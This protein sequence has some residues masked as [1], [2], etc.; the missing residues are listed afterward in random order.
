VALKFA[1]TPAL[2][3][4]EREKLRPAL[5]HEAQTLAQVAPD[6]E[7][8]LY[9]RLS[10]F[11][12][13]RGTTGDPSSVAVSLRRVETAIP[14]RGTSCPRPWRIR[15]AYAKAS[16]RQANSGYLRLNP[17]IEKSRENP[18][19][20]RQGLRLPHHGEQE[21]GGW[22]RGTTGETPVPLWGQTVPA[23]LR[24]GG[25]GAAEKS[26]Q[27]KASRAKSSQKKILWV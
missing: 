25:R 13:W 8:G 22:R 10:G 16:A 24:P 6:S 17:T 4:G 21:H 27:I 11:A 20:V 19:R 2:S 14:L 23:P 7:R 3:P 9:G 5:V 18:S 12:A 15:P 1:L 26:R